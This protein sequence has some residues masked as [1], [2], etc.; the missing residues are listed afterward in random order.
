MAK[1]RLADVLREEAQNPSKF[2]GNVIQET[3]PNQPLNPDAKPSETEPLNQTTLEAS[4]AS[5]STTSRARRSS[6]TKVE[7]VA[8]MTDLQETLET[9]HQTEGSLQ[10]QIISLQSDLQDQKSLV[11]DLQAELEQANQ[12]KVELAQAKEM[13]LKLS[14]TNATNPQAPQ[15]AD[16]SSQGDESIRFQKAGLNKLPQHSIRSKPLPKRRA[17]SSIDIGWVD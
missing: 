14:K 15:E 11:Q 5:T 6:P 1:R 7:L 9:A 13:I 2:E 8:T 3:D 17:N 4:P 16:S 12:L 10:K